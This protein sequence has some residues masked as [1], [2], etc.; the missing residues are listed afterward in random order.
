[1]EEVREEKVRT[2]VAQVADPPPAALRVKPT[3]RV[4][5]YEKTLAVV[6]AP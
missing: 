5:P 3:E 4:M 1:M 2:E 6:L